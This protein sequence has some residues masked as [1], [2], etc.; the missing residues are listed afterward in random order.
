MRAA[1]RHLA[2]SLSLLLLPAEVF[3]QLDPSPAP[4][5]IRPELSCRV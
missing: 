1:L 4:F 3:A 5:V 2:L